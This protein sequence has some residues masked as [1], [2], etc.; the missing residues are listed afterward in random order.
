MECLFKSVMIIRE[1]AMHKDDLKFLKSLV[2]ILKSNG[3][4]PCCNITGEYFTQIAYDRKGGREMKLDYAHGT[5]SVHI[6][7]NH[8]RD[9]NLSVTGLA[10]IERYMP[11]IVGEK[12][13]EVETLN[14][15]L[16]ESIDLAIGYM[17][18]HT[19]FTGSGNLAQLRAMKIRNPRLFARLVKNKKPPVC[20]TSCLPIQ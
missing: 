4:R 13:T 8:R 1:L 14:E 3:V 11:F 12:L 15:T 7:S 16:A 2:G 17:H 9:I 5:N 6:H 10:A 20:D 19:K 18:M